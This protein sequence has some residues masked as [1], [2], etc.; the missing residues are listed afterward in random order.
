MFI[1]QT[2]SLIWKTNLQDSINTNP[3]SE[4]GYIFI[5]T[6]LG[7]CC[8]LSETNGDIIWTYLTN[9]PVFGSACFVTFTEKYICWPNV[10]GTINCISCSNGRL[11]ILLPSES[12]DYC[13]SACRCGLTKRQT[14]YLL[15]FCIITAT[16]YL[17][18]KIKV[19][20]A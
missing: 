7:N 8:C 11:V 2:G 12:H 13:T 19:Y 20:I 10:S 5:A 9:F 15:L 17:G 14:K 1:F 3:F 18:V 4:G 6:I 16:L